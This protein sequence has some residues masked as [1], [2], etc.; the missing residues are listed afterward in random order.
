MPIQ[1][2][3]GYAIPY[4]GEPTQCPKCAS[5]F[6]L[7]DRSFSWRLGSPFPAGTIT[8]GASIATKQQ[9]KQARRDRKRA[10]RTG[11]KKK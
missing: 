10:S 7:K 11:W 4:E 9:F 3:C 6:Y 1:C 2:Y 5:V 8:V